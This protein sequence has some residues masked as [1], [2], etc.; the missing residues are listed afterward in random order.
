MC[1]AYLKESGAK[2]AQGGIFLIGIAY[3]F[4]NLKSSFIVNYK[5]NFQA[6]ITI[7]ISVSGVFFI[8]FNYESSHFARE[9]YYTFVSLD[10]MSSSLNRAL[11]QYSGLLVFFSS[12]LFGYGY[13]AVYY[14]KLEEV[15]T[16]VVVKHFFHFLRKPEEFTYWSDQSAFNLFL[17][18]LSMFGLTGLGYNIFILYIF[19][20]TYRILGFHYLNIAPLVVVM[21]IGWGLGG[22]WELIV[23]ATFVLVF[24]SVGE[25]P[26]DKKYLNAYPKR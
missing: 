18:N 1:F 11:M 24:L 16:E 13:G 3:F 12:P 6:L 23:W 19:Y 10:R 7:G 14:Q 8:L 22:G 4:K 17:D 21:I 26:H 5:L 20:K 25:S 2:A 9:L 15:A